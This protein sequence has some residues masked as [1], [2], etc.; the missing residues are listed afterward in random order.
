MPPMSYRVPLP[1]LAIALA[2]LLLGGCGKHGTDQPS[3]PPAV[4]SKPGP[5]GYGGS[6]STLSI[7][8]RFMLGADQEA[9]Q[10]YLRTVREVK[11]KKFEV[12]WN[13]DTVAVSREEAMRA[14]RS[15]DAHGSEFTFSKDEPVVAKLVPGRILWIW[16]IALCRIDRIDD[17]GHTIAV[18]TRPIALTE[19]MTDAKIE[20]EAP[21]HFGDAYGT[22]RPR[23]P[24]G[25]PAAPHASTARRTSPFRLV[26]FP[27]VSNSP[28]APA[29]EGGGSGDATGDEKSDES[30]D[31]VAGTMDGFNGKIL[32]FEYAIGYK[33]EGEKLDLQIEGRKEEEGGGGAAESNEITKEHRREFFEAIHEQ[34]EA[35]HRKDEAKHKWE[36]VKKLHKELDSE[37]DT[38]YHDPANGS[39]AGKSEA[40]QEGVKALGRLGVAQKGPTAQE[41]SDTLDR[42][43]QAEE[44]RIRGEL[45]DLAHEYNQ[46][47]TKEHAAERKAK[48]LALAGAIA[49]HV[50]EIVSENVDMRF[51][52][53]V[54]VDGAVASA[55][56][57]IASGQMAAAKVTFSQ[58]SGRV[59][60]EL[61]G[62]LGQPGTGIISIPVAHI[63][64]GFN[65]PLPID[66]IPFVIEVGADFLLKVGM[67]GQHATQHIDGHYFFGGDAGMHSAASGAGTDGGIEAKELEFNNEGISPGASAVVLAVQLPKL[68]LGLGMFGAG[69]MAFV[70]VVTVVSN[71]NS[72][73]VAL[74]VPSCQRATLDIVPHVGVE[75]QLM[76]LPIPLL[77]ELGSALLT[78]KVELKPTFHRERITPD[79]QMCKL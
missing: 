40:A 78:Q 19:A 2:A 69:A 72:A 61:I 50:F 5:G 6:P 46:E 52:G 54:Q 71:T 67:S 20:F 68:G 56:L 23:P 76:P 65:V 64:V 58:M 15:I 3:P 11:P 34:H 74:G 27:M 53:R 51:R 70:D 36:H 28:D 14:L 16:D 30:E 59:G 48:K 66:G 21:T 10:G 13:P 12:K 22:Y 73:A 38:Q 77:A 29:T 37:L 41:G 47:L 39:M 75:I 45:D 8:G 17:L 44:K 31:M 9:I 7:A 33:V 55:A 1:V 57:Q 79:R 49:K 43:G 18:H 4:S 63:P 32:G 24:E 26:S 60:F 42:L 25:P 62:R 35:R